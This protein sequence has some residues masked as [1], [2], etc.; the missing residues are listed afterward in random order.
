ME[1]KK[2]YEVPGKKILR[3]YQMDWHKWKITTIKEHND[4]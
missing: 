2:Y 4:K 1:D 3:F